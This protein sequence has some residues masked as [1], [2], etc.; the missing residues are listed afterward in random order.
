MP[1]G[2]TLTVDT[3]SVHLDEKYAVQN[4][5]V[6]PGDYALLSV[7]DTGTGMS[8]EILAQAFE[9]FFTTKRASKGTGLGLSMVYGFVKQ[10][11]GHI[12]L[13]S[14]PGHGTTVKVYLPC[15]KDATAAEAL[16]REPGAPVR[17]V[18]GEII[19][20]VDDNAEM[21][22]VSAKQLQDLGYKTVETDSGQAA[23]EIL[24]GGA[25]IDL[26]F[27]DVVMPGGV[28][29][30]QL[31]E[32]ARQIRPG[33]K[34]L[35]TSGFSQAAEMKGGKLGAGFALL[36]KPYRKRDLARRVRETLDRTNGETS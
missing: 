34:V 26:L 27:T 35:F 29:G 13:Y 17:A 8:P 23:L 6:D 18:D 14:E 24:K 32:A 7:S 3:S 15:A 20:V 9:P 10:S 22:D 16:G 19:L 21:R 2:G 4:L 36:S 33:I 5:E 1:E 12:K 30:Y 31:A 11:G 25:G 28:S